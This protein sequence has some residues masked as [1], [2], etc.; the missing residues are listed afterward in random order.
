LLHPEDNWTSSDHL[1]PQILYAFEGINRVLF[2]FIRIVQS[3]FSC[4]LIYKQFLKVFWQSKS[5]NLAISKYEKITHTYT[6][7]TC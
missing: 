6:H 4:S 1:I 7:E 2:M 5:L 3:S